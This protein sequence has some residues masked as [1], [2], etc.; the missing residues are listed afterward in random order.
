MDLIH[1]TSLDPDHLHVVEIVLGPM[2]AP[3]SVAKTTAAIEAFNKK[4]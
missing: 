3:M 4:N 1:G 2:D